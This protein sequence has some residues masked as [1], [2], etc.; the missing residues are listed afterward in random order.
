MADIVAEFKRLDVPAVVYLKRRRAGVDGPGREVR[1]IVNEIP[2]LSAP[3]HLVDGPGADWSGAAIGRWWWT[4]AAGR[5]AA[6]VGR[7][8]MTRNTPRMNGWI[9]QK[10][11]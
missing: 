8:R 10:N 11:V 6:P 1:R 5:A 9:R 3:T 7:Q 4:A 2:S